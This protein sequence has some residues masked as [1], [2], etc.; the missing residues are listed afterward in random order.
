[1]DNGEEIPRLND[2]YTFMGAGIPEWIAGFASFMI[3]SEMFFK[4]ALATSMPFLLI[5]WVGTTAGLATLRSRFPDE[6]RGVR[7][8]FMTMCGF[9]P[10]GIPAPAPLQP[11]WSGAPLREL[12]E[13]CEFSEL[14]LADLFPEEDPGKN[15]N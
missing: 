4:G 1:M 5:I 15:E 2:N 14:N 6:Q 11:Y 10:P 13:K 8:F 9:E 3:A 7:N 12:R